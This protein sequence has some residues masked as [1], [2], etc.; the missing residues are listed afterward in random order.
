MA[1]GNDNKA[2]V[3]IQ[4]GLGWLIVLSFAGV[5]ISLVAATIVWGSP[6]DQI[7]LLKQALNTL[8]NIVLVVTGFFYGSS[9]SS[10]SK[11]ET[12]AKVTE[13]LADRMAVNGDKAGLMAAA[14]AVA[15]AAAAA[16]EKAAPPAVE[17]AVEEA[18]DARKPK[19]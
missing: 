2:W 17:K 13:K 5:I 16:A 19:E 10:Q 1:N 6:A 18:L 14:L 12:Q 3:D 7:E 8:F 15:P 11:D 9:R 4:R